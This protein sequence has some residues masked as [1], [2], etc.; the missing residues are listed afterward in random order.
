MAY[1]YIEVDPIAGSLGAEVSGVDLS[2]QLPEE[3]FN[4]IHQ[5]LM[6]HLVIFF[7]NQGLTPEQHKE[8][9]RRFGRSCP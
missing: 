5:A 4:E 8:F 7:R 3:V 1:Q 6:D 2:R 9:S